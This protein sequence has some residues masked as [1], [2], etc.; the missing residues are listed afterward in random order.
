MNRQIKIQLLFFTLVRTVLNT[1]YRMVYP[2]LSVFA[3]GVGVEISAMATALTARSLAGTLGPFLASIADSRGRK[4]GML[5]G[6]GLFVAGVSLVVFWPS[7]LTLT[8]AVVLA[9]LGKYN[10]DPS[11]Q[12]YLGERIPYQRRGLS[13]A[14]TELGWS[15]AFIAGIPLVGFLIARGGWM[16]PFV[17]LGILGILSAAGVFLL[18]PADAPQTS[19]AAALLHNFR[20][21]LTHRPSLAGLAAGLLATAANEMVNLIFGVWLEDSFGVKITALVA[22]SA[23]IGISELGGEGLVARWT[24]RLGKPRAIA[25]GLLANT[26]AAL[27]LP[28][29]GQSQSGALIGLFF[30]YITFEFTLV[31]MIS[32]MTE[33]QPAAR[34][35]LMAFN[36]AGHSLGRAVGDALAI[37]IYALGFFWVVAASVIFNM[38]AFISVWWL[39]RHA[40]I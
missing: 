38:L 34:A 27:G 5:F 10:F 18:I 15:L 25:L 21:V 31:S 24:D 14:I 16:S 33:I 26:L 1:M 7:F 4:A 29:A 2:F 9:T 17:L 39:R 22:A 36:V 8:I 40:P 19:E 37:S 23:V 6:L 30:F 20:Q 11:M 12:A 35:T 32:M 13:I 3:R 28:L